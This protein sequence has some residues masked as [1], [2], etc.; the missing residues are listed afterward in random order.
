VAWPV[1]YRHPRARREDHW[2]NARFQIAGDRR[3]CSGRALRSSR[4]S[5][6]DVGPGWSSVGSPAERKQGFNT[7]KTEKRHG[8]SRRRKCGA[9]CGRSIM[10]RSMRSKLLLFRENPCL[11]PV[12][13]VFRHLLV[14]VLA[15]PSQHRNSDGSARRCV[16]A[17]GSSPS[18]TVSMRL[19]ATSR[20]RA[21]RPAAR[22]AFFPT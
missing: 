3:G 20:S 14:E 6:S 8:L 1:L 10:H 12:F 4:I 11:A 7:E 17:V 15:P 5:N 16:H 9:S 19:Y 18:T 21:A 2:Q 22:R 13:S